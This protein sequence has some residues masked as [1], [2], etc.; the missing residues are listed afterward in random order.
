MLSLF[1][2]FLLAVGIQ[3][4]L[5][6]PA[7]YLKTDRFTDLSYGLTF[8]V[9]S[10][11]SLQMTSN[12][13]FKN[14]LFGMIILWA[15]RLVGHLALRIRKLGNDPRF[16]SIRG[17]FWKFAAFWAFQGFA[18]W[19]ILLPSLFFFYKN[20]PSPSYLTIIGIWVW[21]AGFLIEAIADRQKLEFRRDMNNKWI[22]SGLWAYS[23]H[24]NYFGEV[25]CWVGLYLFAFA[26]LVPAE[27]LFGLLSPILIA[28]LLLF[29]TGIPI[30][31]RLADK[32]WGRFRDYRDY[33]RRTS[34]FVPL[35][36]LR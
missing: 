12:S 32:K 11:V 26:S 17:D 9:L 10:F 21:L 2:L 29:V 6:V 34:A 7:Y 16:D 31:E 24:P 22:D 20:D 28:F 35:P 36:K 3:A 25:L 8:I 13:V 15:L 14:L 23:R 4:F 1:G 5:F 30:L 33:K 18:A 19:A 27:R